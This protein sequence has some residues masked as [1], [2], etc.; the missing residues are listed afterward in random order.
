[1]KRKTEQQLIDG[2]SISTG[3]RVI[4]KSVGTIEDR[5]ILRSKTSIINN[6]GF[7]TGA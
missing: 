5:D 4:N 7:F 3:I 1:M 6:G 2:K